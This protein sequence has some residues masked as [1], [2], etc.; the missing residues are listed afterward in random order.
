LKAWFQGGLQIF[1]FFY[2]LKQFFI[3]LY[4]VPNNSL[5]EAIF[6]SIHML[7]IKLAFK[8]IYEKMNSLL[9]L[10]IA[11]HVRYFDVTGFLFSKRTVLRDDLS[12]GLFLFSVK[13]F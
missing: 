10:W 12:D 7:Y 1:I 3:F 2:F 5:T 4:C 8:H 9:M 6:K 11:W 13:F